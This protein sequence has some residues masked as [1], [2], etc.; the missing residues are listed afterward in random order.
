[1]QVTGP[2]ENMRPQS[3]WHTWLEKESFWHK[4]ELFIARAESQQ[5]AQHK[6]QQAKARKQRR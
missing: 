4:L 5:E 1:V 2:Y 3:V 6:R